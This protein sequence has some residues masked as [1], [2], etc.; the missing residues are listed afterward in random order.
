MSKY[1]QT[2][3]ALKYKP[4][5]WLVTGVAGFIGSHLL[6]TLLK[7][8]QKVIGIDNY[9]T[10]NK[11]NLLLVRSS[12][13]TNQWNNFDMIV[14][15]VGS[16][17]IDAITSVD[18]VLHQAALCSVQQSM[19][20][21]DVYMYNNVVN[22]VNLLTSCRKA[23]IKRLVFASS[24][25]VYGDAANNSEDV[26]GEAQSVYALTK[27]INEHCARLYGHHVETI[28][29][30]YYNIFGERQNYIGD[31]IAVIPKWIK[32]ILGKQ[33]ITIFG[34]GSFSRDY[35]HVDNVVQANILAATTN[36]AD[37]LGQNFNVGTGIST[38]LN[39]LYKIVSGILESVPD[40]NIKLLYEDSQKNCVAHSKADIAKIKN[41]LQYEPSDT[42]LSE[43][44]ISI[45]HNTLKNV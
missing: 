8:D 3:E 18:V 19:L 32:S 45:I 12:V 2:L 31:N 28:G 7:H 29:L 6:E 16:I 15:S 4:K 10:G 13:T 40:T 1:T 11:D 27:Q 14:G 43:G 35:C 5:T 26:V 24:S 41:M 20:M 36:N 30:R 39:E 22:F 21:P 25:A 33:P 37:A 38:T 9:S 44:L 42:S 17:N 23:K 34:D